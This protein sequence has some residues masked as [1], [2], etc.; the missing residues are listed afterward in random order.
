[1]DKKGLRTGAW[2][3]YYPDGK[4]MSKINYLNGVK[5]GLTVD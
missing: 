1:L 4:I 5:N 3:N 2:K